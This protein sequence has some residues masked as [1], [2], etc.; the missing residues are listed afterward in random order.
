MPFVAILLVVSTPLRERALV[1]LSS[2]KAPARV[3]EIEVAHFDPDESVEPG[4]PSD[5]VR[6]DI[7]TFVVPKA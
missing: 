7:E 6:H 5:S 3:I 4:G 1:A 2:N